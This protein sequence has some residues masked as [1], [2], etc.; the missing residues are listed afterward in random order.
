MYVCV[1]VCVCVY[2]VTFNQLVSRGDGCSVRDVRDGSVAKVALRCTDVRLRMSDDV[3]LC[4]P[5]V[6]SV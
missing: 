1:C 2:I 3:T 4:Y 5:L 6:G